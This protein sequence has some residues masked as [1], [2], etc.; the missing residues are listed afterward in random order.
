MKKKILSIAGMTAALAAGLTTAILILSPAAS[1]SPTTCSGTTCTWH[2]QGLPMESKCDEQNTPYIHWVFTAKDITSATVTLGG[3]GSGSYVMD[4]HSKGSW[5][6]DTPYFDVN[7]LTASVAF[8]VKPDGDIGNAQF[9]ISH[10]CA[11]QTTT[12]TETTPTGTT[13]VTVP[14][15][16]TVTTPGTTVTT[17]GTTVTTPSTTVTT[18]GSTTTVTTTTTTTTPGSKPPKHHKGKPTNV[19]NKKKLAYTP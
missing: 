11:G 10:G 3:S 8:V 1:A 18:P 6:V 5:E 19:T 4:E 14:V 12:T 15:T 9:T 16:T 13:T 2:G 7:S 17:P